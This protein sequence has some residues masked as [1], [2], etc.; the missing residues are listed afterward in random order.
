MPDRTRDWNGRCGGPAS[1]TR[2]RTHCDHDRG[3]VKAGAAYLPLDIDHPAARVLFMLQDSRACLV[4]TT[5]EILNQLPQLS[6]FPLLLIDDAQ[7]RDRIDGFS[8]A[9]ITDSERL[10]PLLL[11]NLLYV[12]YTSGSTGEPKGVAI[13]HRS[14]SLQMKKMVRRIPMST[15]ETILG[16]TTITF[17]PAAFEIF[18]PLLQGASLTLLGSLESRDP[19]SVASAVAAVGGCVLQATPTFWRALFDCGIPPTVRAFVGGEALPAELVPRFLELAEATNLYGPTETTVDS[20]FHK[21]IPE[22]GHRNPVVTIGRPLEGEQFYIL[23][24]N[25]APV[26][27]GVTGELFIAGSGLARGYLNRPA[28][29]RERFVNCPFATDGSLMYRTGDLA[30]WRSNGEVDYLGRADQQVKIRGIRIEPGEIEASLSRCVPEIRECAVVAREIRGQLQLVAYYTDAAG[31]AAP[32]AR[33]MRELL[34]KSLPD[35]MLPGIFVRQETMPLTLNG[36]LDRKALPEPR[37]DSDRSRFLPPITPEEAVICTTFADLTGAERVSRDDDFFQLGGHSLAAV[38]CVHRLQREL[39]CEVTL[40]QLF[41]APT[42][43]A[44][45][46][47]LFHG[48]TPE[49]ARLPAAS[50]P[51]LFMLPGVCGDEPRLVRFRLQCESSMRIVLLTY[52]DWRLMTD[53]R[54]G[55]RL[56]VRHL[57]QQIQSETPEGP[58]R[59]LG[60][61]FGGYCSHAIAVELSRVGRQVEFIGLLDASALPDLPIMLSTQL[62]DGVSP[63]RV[64]CFL[65]QD[66]AR[67]ARAIAQREFARVS[68]L[69]LVRWLNA[70]LAKPL[71]SMAARP[72]DCWLSSWFDYYLNHYFKESTRVAAMKYWYESIGRDPVQ[73]VS[74][75]FLFRSEDHLPEEPEDLGWHRYFAAVATINLTGTHHTILDPPHLASVCE[76]TSKLV[77]AV[78][79]RA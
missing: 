46:R 36:K 35:S 9:R 19:V 12:I 32:A 5:T 56:L 22:D 67:L 13:E 52:P 15:E 64:G 49:S 23:D 38:L 63:L 51:L 20:S 70:P 18:L 7:Q 10:R 17:D 45:A 14:F 42:P 77:A 79:V 28:L 72:R 55:A 73:L 25:L 8:S 41:E 71:F 57:V 59:L 30:Q 4:V 76:E 34:S 2:N 68:A 24:A 69:V 48:R 65:L 1:P 40:R 61:S 21:I 43:E 29:T 3:V 16:I 53:R 75:A 26:P 6:S 31:F 47:A 78:P 50:R 11:E 58:V 44:L 54:T 33:Q 62:Q 39:Q 60:Y 27:T 74:P 37:L 66:L